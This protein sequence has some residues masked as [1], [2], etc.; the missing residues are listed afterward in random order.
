MNLDRIKP[1]ICAVVGHDY[2]PLAAVDGSVTFVCRRCG[3][4]I[5]MTSGFRPNFSH[6]MPA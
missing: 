3:K 4:I 2:Q 6:L 5:K 1:L